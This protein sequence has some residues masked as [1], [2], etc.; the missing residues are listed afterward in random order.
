MGSEN[1]LADRPRA[2]GLSAFGRFEQG[3]AD[4]ALQATDL[5]GER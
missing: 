4:V 2:Y 3:S 1:M 5:G